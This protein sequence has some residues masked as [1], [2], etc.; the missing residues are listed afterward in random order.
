M[1]TILIV[2]DRPTN[3]ECL[4]T[5]LGYQDHRVLQAADGA[6]ALALA[7]SEKPDLVISDILMPTMDGYEFVQCLR[8]DPA[9]ADIPVIFNTAHY[10]DREARALANTCRIS[11]IIHKP[12]EPAVVLRVVSEVLGLTPVCEPLGQNEVGSPG[13]PLDLSVREEGLTLVNERLTALIEL[14]HQLAVERS[15]VSLLENFCRSARKIIGAKYA[16]V[17]ML[18]DGSSLRYFLTSGMRADAF[19]DSENLPVPD[20]LFLK[21]LREGKPL[22]L[23]DVENHPRG[24]GVPENHPEIR[25]FLGTAIS[26]PTQVYGAFYLGEK[27]GLDQFSKE[28]EELVVAL[29]AQLG[30]TYE[31]ARRFEEV[32]LRTQ[33]LAQEISERGRAQDALRASE[34]RFATFFNASPIPMSIVSYEDGRYIDVNESFLENSGYARD[35]IIGC[36]TSEIGIYAYAEEREGLKA[37]LEQG[38]TIHNAEMHRR[39]KS[40]EVRVALSSSEMIEIDGMRCV[41]TANNDITERKRAEEARISSEERLASIID[42]AMDAII[43][44]DADQRIVLFN[45]AAEEI[46][47]CSYADAIGQSLDRFVPARFPDAHRGHIQNFGRTNVTTRSMGSLSPISGLRAGGEEFPIE[48]SISQVEVDGRKLYTVIIRDVTDRKRT[49]EEIAKKTTELEQHTRLLDLAQVLVRDANDD[50][51]I[52]WNRGAKEFYGWTKEEALGRSSQELLQ[53][54]FPKSQEEIQA[55]ILAEGHWEGELTHTCRDGTRVTVASHQ[56]LHRNE[57]GEPTAILE[58]NNDIT[59]RKQAE[60][61][62]AEHALRLSTSEDALRAKNEELQTMS[63]QLWH[64]AKLAAVGELAASIAHELNN[65]LATVSLRIDSLLSQTPEDDTAHRSLSIVGEEVQRMANLV[66]NLLQ[67]SR[68]KESQVSTIDIRTEVTGTLE[69]LHSHMRNRNID[70]AMEFAPDAQMVQADRQ[71]LRQVF[72]NVLTNAADAMPDGG[73]LTICGAPWRLNDSDGLRLEFRDT[74]SGIAAEDLPSV[75]EPFFT[76]KPE[77]KGTGLGLAICK[78]IVQE[79]GGCFEITSD[80]GK[81]TSVLISLPVSASKDNLELI[82]GQG[83]ALRAGS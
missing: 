35:E 38:G 16:V 18:E 1:A 4:K 22:R 77:G 71:Q 9:L 70:V 68:R 13:E 82:G 61:R 26:S 62:L 53:T 12:A 5:L 10:L 32:Q 25:S 29:A 57:R 14:G 78:R 23:R 58:T 17:G 55:E 69:L 47:K 54:E 7:K 75:T 65:P 31:N 15:P 30:V 37:L 64:A 42:S 79:H 66:A 48:A 44:V 33:E 72:L 28:D 50:R 43:A 41:L 19:S 6:E 11:H 52:L 73:T 74:G 63:G 60:R 67:F 21:L 3:R 39:V 76:T 83:S 51:I 45:A 80:I 81:G 59:D 34:E 20:G 27:I 2:D 56:V 36:T 24:I 49:E 40:G 46:F 8:A